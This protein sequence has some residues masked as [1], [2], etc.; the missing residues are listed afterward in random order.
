METYNLLVLVVCLRFLKWLITF[1]VYI[2]ISIEKMRAIDSTSTSKQ[3]IPSF[4]LALFRA[5][6]IKELKDKDD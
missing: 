1:I 6:T 4:N 2:S 5:N 3:I